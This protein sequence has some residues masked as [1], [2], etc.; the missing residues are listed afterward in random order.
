MRKKLAEKK[1]IEENLLSAASSGQIGTIQT[2]LRV[3][4]KVSG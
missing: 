1:N 4:R 2:L 3:F